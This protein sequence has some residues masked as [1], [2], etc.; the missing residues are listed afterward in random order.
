MAN[1]RMPYGCPKAR[2]LASARTPAGE[3]EEGLSLARGTRPGQSEGARE[4]KG[5]GDAGGERERT[6][7]EKRTGDGRESAAGWY[8]GPVIAK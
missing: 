7:R 2:A 4:E 5:E 8:R 3:S 1:A 6:A